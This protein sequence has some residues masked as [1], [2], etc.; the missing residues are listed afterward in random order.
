[1]IFERSELR[2]AEVRD[3]ASVTYL[4]GE[5]SVAEEGYESGSFHGHDQSLLSGACLDLLRW[6]E[7]PPEP[8]AP[9]ASFLAFGGAHPDGFQTAFCD[10]HVRMLGYDVDPAVH[11]TLGDRR[12]GGPHA[13][14]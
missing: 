9:G 6:T 2:P 8:D 13:V 5:K 11:R 14:P 10:G 1:M 4:L 12:D 7:Q 3:G